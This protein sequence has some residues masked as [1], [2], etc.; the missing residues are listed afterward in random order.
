VSSGTAP[1]GRSIMLYVAPSTPAACYA[2]V[3]P[4]AMALVASGI[5]LL[6]GERIVFL[7]FLSPRH[8]QRRLRALATSRGREGCC[9]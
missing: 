7:L 2:I 3:A 6:L 4:Q 1:R 5:D 9:R 8:R